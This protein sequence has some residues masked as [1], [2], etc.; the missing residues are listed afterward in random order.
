MSDGDGW[1]LQV[2]PPVLLPGR[3]ATVTLSFTPDRDLQS[4]GVSAVL[5]CVERYRYDTAE[6]STGA[7]GTTSTRRVTHTDHN[8][9]HRL[10]FALAGPAPM[11][12]GQAQ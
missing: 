6:H 9:I 10:E 4:R 11:A 3:S 12:S 1:Q 8:E 2:D 5:R 7:N